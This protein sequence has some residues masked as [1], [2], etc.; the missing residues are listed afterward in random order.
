[1]SQISKRPLKPGIN[2]KVFDLFLKSLLRNNSKRKIEKFL[3]ALISKTERIMLSKRI[4]IFYLLIKGLDYRAI[5][6]NLKVSTATVAK[7]AI[8]LKINGGRIEKTLKRILLEKKIANNLEALGEMVFNSI[9]PKSGNWSQWAK[10]KS[11]RAKKRSSI[12]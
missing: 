12:L 10:N 7:F 6:R 11:S 1:M 2:E 8:L 3:E 5:S 4:A 9:P